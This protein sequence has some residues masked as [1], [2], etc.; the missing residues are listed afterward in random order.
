VRD[1]GA[2]VYYRRTANSR[3]SDV[4]QSARS[5]N[6]PAPPLPR[7]RIVLVPDLAGP[8]WVISRDLLIVE[9]TGDTSV[10]GPRLAAALADAGWRLATVIL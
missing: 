8:P 7:R 4:P 3:G 6:P 9:V 5:L 2:L 1:V 10:D